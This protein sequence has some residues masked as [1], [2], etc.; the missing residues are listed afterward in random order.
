MLSISGT[1]K[2]PVPTGKIWELLSKPGYLIHV[3]PFVKSND[4]SSWVGVGSS[5]H[6]TY[7]NDKE[8]IRTVQQWNDQ[9][10]L[11]LSIRPAEQKKQENQIIVHFV[12]EKIA[13]SESK[14]T[15]QIDLN[16]YRNIPRPLWIILRPLIF[17]PGYKKYIHHLI[18]GYYNF[19]T[20]NKSVEIEEFGRHSWFRRETNNLN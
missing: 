7:I 3:N 1:Y 19:L 5:D 16:S 14:F 20:D 8:F 17:I 11:I 6:F 10:G 12:Y 4:S 15:V 9:N 18:M 2:I 13:A